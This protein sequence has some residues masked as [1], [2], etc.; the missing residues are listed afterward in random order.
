MDKTVFILGAGASVEAGIPAMADF[1]DRAQDL[2]DS[3]L[4]NEEEKKSF[5]NIFQAIRTLKGV[6]FHTDL[7]LN[8]LEVV[9]GLFDMGRILG[10]MGNYNANEIDQLYEDLIKVIG[11]TIDLCTVVRTHNDGSQSIPGPYP[12]FVQLLKNNFVNNDRLMASIVSF[13]YDLALDFAM[14]CEGIIPR[15]YVNEQN[16]KGNISLLKLHGSLNWGE[17]NRGQ[18]EPLNMK[19]LLGNGCLDGP[20]SE[21]RLIVSRKFIAGMPFNGYSIRGPMIV[22]PTWNKAE[23]RYNVGAVWQEAVNVIAE[24]RAIYVVGYSLPETDMFFR[25]LFSLAAHSDTSIK[26]FW[27]FDPFPSIKNRYTNMLGPGLREPRFQFHEKIFSKAIT[28][29]RE[30]I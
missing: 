12:S 11:I 19:S 27:V 8:N 24:A 29:I 17:G 15:Y 22:P 21:S 9:F 3:N 13:N 23:H 2:R 28:H 10:K 6:S 7:D 16:N 14:H 18:V 30:N 26:R 5:S 1:L 25:Y 4:L 20:F